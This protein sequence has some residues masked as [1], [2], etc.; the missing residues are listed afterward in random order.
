MILFPSHSLAAREAKKT[1]ATRSEKDFDR[2]VQEETS[3]R[4]VEGERRFLFSSFTFSYA[5]RNKLEEP[6]RRLVRG[7]KVP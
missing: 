1:F 6:S 3:E 2:K 5:E 7:A 4:R